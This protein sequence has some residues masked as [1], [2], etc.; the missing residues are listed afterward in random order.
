MSTT[1][2]NGRQRKSLAEQIDRLDS[3][4]DG[5]G[6][7]LERSGRY[8]VKEAVRAVLSEMLTNPEVLTRLLA[9]QQVAGRHRADRT[10]GGARGW[11]RVRS[12][13]RWT[14]ERGRPVGR[15]GSA[16]L[17]AVPVQMWPKPLVDAATIPCGWWL[18][19]Q[20]ALRARWLLAPILAAAVLAGLTGVAA[21]H[22]GPWMAA[23][24]SGAGE[25][26]GRCDQTR[27]LAEL[28]LA[29]ADGVIGLLN[30]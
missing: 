5:F 3:V 18:L 19:A 25:V 20:R 30:D 11:D 17:S 23:G 27:K 24:V 29:V 1:L 16:S 6:G 9:A 7:R 13:L 15:H 21:Y 26:R 2:T 22:L 10:D 14:A 12:T 4:L 28:G 8:A